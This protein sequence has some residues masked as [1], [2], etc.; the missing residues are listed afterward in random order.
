MSRKYL[1]IEIEDKGFVVDM[2]VLDSKDV[3]LQ[4]GYVEDKVFKSEKQITL[5]D[6]KKGGFKLD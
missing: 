4:Y 3:K 1:R 2:S 6:L 5:K